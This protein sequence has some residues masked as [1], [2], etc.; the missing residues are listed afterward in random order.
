MDKDDDAL[1]FIVVDERFQRTYDVLCGITMDYLNLRAQELPIDMF[2][3]AH[4]FFPYDFNYSPSSDLSPSRDAVDD[5][6][7]APSM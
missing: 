2:N 7:R 5:P 4:H 3:T 1:S 6:F